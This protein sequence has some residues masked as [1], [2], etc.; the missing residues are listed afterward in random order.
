MDILGGTPVSAGSPLASHIVAILGNDGTHG[1]LCTGVL[2]TKNKVLT[3]GH[4]GN[5]LH[6]GQILF[7]T[8]L[9]TSDTSLRRQITGVKVQPRF[10]EALDRIAARGGRPVNSIKNWGDLAVMT[11]AGGMPRG[12]SPALIA[13]ND[14]LNDGDPVILAGFGLLDGAKAVG[15]QNLNSVT[16]PVKKARYSKSEFTV[17]QSEGKGACHG[18]SGGPA[19]VEN[20][21]ELYLAGITSRGFD[22]VCAK[23]T[24][25]T[26]VSFFIDWIEETIRE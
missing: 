16:V 26:R 15:S 5:E 18:D 23:A 2:L 25:Y 17:D 6:Q 4:C 19:M 22:D 13:G 12:F 7:S 10:G 8:D 20:G 3:A 1:F 14:I 21:G 11:F 9:S 24:V